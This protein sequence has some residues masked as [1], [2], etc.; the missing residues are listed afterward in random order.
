MRSVFSI[1]A[2]RKFFSLKQ[3]KSLIQRASLNGFTDCQIILGNDALRFFLDDMSVSIHGKNY[4]SEV[5]KQALI[6]GNIHYYADPNGHYLNQTEMNELL[7]FAR[8]QRIK[9]IPVINSPGHMDAILAA[10]SYLGIEKPM[11]KESKRTVDLENLAAVSFSKEL[12]RKY[13]N[14]FSDSCEIFNIGGDEYANDV[15][16]G[17]W[18]KLQDSG[19]YGEF[20]KYVN[21]LATMIKAADMKPMIF[22]D[23]IYYNNDDR[24]GSFDQDLVVAYWTAGWEG[25]HVAKPDYLVRKKHQLLNTNDVWYWVVGHIDSGIYQFDQALESMQ[26]RK[27]TEVPTSVNVPII[28]SMQCVWTDNPNEVHDFERIDQLMTTFSTCYSPYMQSTLA[29]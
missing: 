6:H 21:D 27:F 1:D 18:Q 10:M 19:L 20:I 2:G 16:T 11:F 3:L 28:G 7:L 23:G 9:I 4:G 12:I 25:Y 26:T 15:D 13:V 29:D 14:Y 24:F 17:G 22:N 5:V 8:Q